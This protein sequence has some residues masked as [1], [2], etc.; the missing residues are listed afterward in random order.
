MDDILIQKI[1]VLFSTLSQ[2]LRLLDAQGDSLVP[3]DSASYYLPDAML[4]GEIREHNAYHFMRLN[5]SESLNLL[6]PVSDYSA[7]LLRLAAGAIEAI[8]ELYPQSRGKTDAYRRLMTEDAA[9][10]EVALLIDEHRIPQNLA[11]C[12]VLI[13]L[14]SVKQQAYDLLQGLMPLEDKDVLLP[15]D[16]NKVLLI[17][18]L[19]DPHSLTEAKEYAQALEETVREESSFSISCGIGGTHLLA[20]GLR[21]SYLQAKQALDV[22]SQY[23]LKENIFVWH[24][25]LLP[26]FFCEIP[27]ERARYYHSLVFNKKT[28]RHLTDEM[29]QTVEMFLEKDLNMSETARHLYIHRNTLVYRLDKVQRLVGLDLRKFSDAFLFKMLYDLKFRLNEKNMRNQ[30]R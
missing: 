26:R 4:G 20:T 15:F 21:E 6:C 22:G 12:V 7:D 10:E 5:S 13:K 19:E 27:V 28:S 9:E 25:M 3:K 17:K 29:I 1:T 14:H 2:E 16:A 18:A 30:D 11:R 8:A 23:F 24:D